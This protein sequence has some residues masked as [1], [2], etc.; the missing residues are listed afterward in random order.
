MRLREC[1]RPAPFLR[2]SLARAFHAGQVALCACR[3]AAAALALALAVGC[4]STSPKQ[5]PPASPEE[6][7]ETA[8][9]SQLALDRWLANE[10]RL[11][12]IS[13]QVQLR[14]RPLCGED[15]APVLGFGVVGRESVPR[16]LAAAA[17]ARYPDERVRVID[18]FP[19][20]AAEQSG[21]RVDDVVLAVGSADVRSPLAVYRPRRAV[22]DTVA[23]RI[24]RGDQ[25]LEIRIP[26][27]P[28]CAYPA[29]LALGSEV[30]AHSFLRS[31]VT[32]FPVGLLRA[33]ESDEQLAFVL[34]HEMGHI[35]LHRTQMSL[36]RYETENQA[37]YIGA[38]LAVRAGF[39]LDPEDVKI[40]DLLSLG[41]VNVI[42][43]RS[44]T[45]PVTPARSFAL[46]ETLREIEHKRTSGVALVPSEKSRLSR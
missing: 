27:T 21:L 42:D 4:T 11:Q 10:I 37:D 44:S 16:I 34:G 5:L 25:E 22:G 36:S 35:I 45:H 14:G 24:L 15:L 2:P 19:G 41:D 39:P 17:E 29:T 9:L 38:Y 1:L 31:R 12:R 30:N 8:R 23:L 3:L 18:V 46:R 7:A 20:M 32:V 28:G 33:V 13:Q 43:R 6:T 40:F 26:H